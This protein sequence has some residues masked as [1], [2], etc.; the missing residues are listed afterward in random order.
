MVASGDKELLCDITVNTG[1]NEA[2]I[3]LIINPSSALTALTLFIAES[4]PKNKEKMVKIVL[5][6]LKG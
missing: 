5:Q 6:L 1:N 2:I 3:I 4:D